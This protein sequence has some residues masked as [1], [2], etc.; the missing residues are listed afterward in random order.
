MEERYELTRSRESYISHGG[1]GETVPPTYIYVSAGHV[2]SDRR[3]IGLSEEAMSG[4]PYGE[5]TISD[6][7]GWKES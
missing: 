5:R 1:T 6:V 7:L 3:D 2:D 4:R